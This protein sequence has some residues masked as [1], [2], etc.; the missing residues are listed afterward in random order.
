MFYVFFLLFA[1]S[2][3]GLS[4]YVD[5]IPKD[6]SLAEVFENPILLPTIHGISVY[7]Q[8]EWE[9]SEIGGVQIHLID[10]PFPDC[11]LESKLESFLELD[12]TQD[13]LDRIKETV[14]ALYEKASRPIVSVFFPQQN[15]TSGYLQMRVVEGSLND[16]QFC[17][18]KYSSPSRLKKMIGIEPGDPID[19]DQV[20]SGL[21]WWNRN[22]FRYTNAIFSPGDSFGTTNMELVTK[23][24]IPVRPF[25]GAD[26]TGNTETGYDR[27]FC[28]IQIG[29]IFGF[30]QIFNY[31]YTVSTDWS[32]F[33]AHT[34]SYSLPVAKQ[35]QLFF[36]GG[37]SQLKARLSSG[38]MDNE[39]RLTQV[40]GRYQFILNPLYGPF[41]HEFHFGYDFKKT[42][43]SIFFGD[44]TVSST[45]PEINQFMMGYYLDYK[46]SR[47]LVSFNA[48][49]FA[50]PF[51]ITADQSNADFQMLRPYAINKY[52]YGRTRL[53]YT[54]FL[55]HEFSIALVGMGQLANQ[56]LLPSEQI[57]LGGYAT[58]RGYTER[59]VN[60]DSGTMLSGELR[61]PPLS[62]VQRWSCKKVRDE[63]LFYA[64]MDYG[65]AHIHHPVSGEKTNIWLLG[66]GPGVKYSLETNISFRAEYGFALHKTGVAPDRTGRWHLGGVISY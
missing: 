66:T 29:S 64:F 48:E 1:C 38:E 3:Q 16:Y 53:S 17:G 27:L 63:L 45:A 49:I 28:G 31:Q 50:S 24:A 15:L 14:I 59:E 34:A 2:L 4:L 6:A 51:Q 22:P 61:M 41:L 33:W 47:Y 7:D 37:Y 19:I 56:N 57:G 18:Q 54:Q 44:F 8:S 35:H 21:A 11:D 5:S 52:I 58:V 40:S 26:N 12:L 43:S 42:N 39:G 60:G 46:A 20:A 32:H 13:R 30:D 23:D 55:P 25:A 9:S 65:L 62:P 10:P 36:F